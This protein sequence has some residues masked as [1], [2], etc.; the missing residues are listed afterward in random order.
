[1]KKCYSLFLLLLVLYSCNDKYVMISEEYKNA[2]FT[3]RKLSVLPISLYRVNVSIDREVSRSYKEDHREVDMVFQD[4]LYSRFQTLLP[5]LSTNIEYEKCPLAFNSLDN[6]GGGSI[7]QFTAYLGK[8]SVEH[9]FRVPTRQALERAGFIPDIALY[10]NRVAVSKRIVHRPGYWANSD[11]IG[12]ELAFNGVNDAGYNYTPPVVHQRTYHP[13]GS[14]TFIDAE[15][16]YVIWDYKADK[17]VAC[18][19]LNSSVNV[20]V[21]ARKRTLHSL[22]DVALRNIIS[23]SPFTARKSS[24]TPDSDE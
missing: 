2:S 16:Q 13:G 17:M 3:D 9:R 24:Y 19:A 11:N 20:F 8:D 22:Y 23:N 15:I 1:M 10:V 21:V 14:S 12:T 4:T 7:K 5:Q 18:G 6:I